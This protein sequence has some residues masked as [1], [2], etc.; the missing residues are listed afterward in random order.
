[1]VLS[2]TF[3]PVISNSPAAGFVVAATR[4]RA[5]SLA[6]AGGAG[7]G[8]G[9]G[10]GAGAGFCAG[11]G[12]GAVAVISPAGVIAGGSADRCVRHPCSM[13]VILTSA[14]TRK[15]IFMA[16]LGNYSTTIM[17]ACPLQP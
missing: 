14:I 15:Y 7:T 8:T 5:G 9:A 11:W 6:G 13:A 2:S 10:T 12:P 4:F 16:N 17:A 3:R 1:M